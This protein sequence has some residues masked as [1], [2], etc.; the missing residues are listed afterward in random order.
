MS[1]PFVEM[2]YARVSSKAQSLAR[3]EQSIIEAVPDL[4]VQYFFKDKYTGKDF[5]NREQYQNMK[6]K[7]QELIEAN[8]STNIRV[9]VHELDR[10]GRDFQEIQKEIQWF[11]TMGVKLRF[12]DIP[13]EL[14]GDAT[15][16]TGQLLY[17]IIILLKS[18]WAEQEL[19]YKEKRVHEGI[20]RAHENG[21]IFGRKAIVVDEKLFKETAGKAVQ[22]N[23]SHV[24]AMKI[25]DMKPYLYWKHIHKY[26]PDYAGKHTTSK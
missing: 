17:R 13:E 6:L 23:I 15:G 8:S 4:K 19:M 22:H 24:D 20:A 21:V 10:L 9:T 12:L 18:Y 25:L 5:E 16:I 26:F 14:I 7:I 1:T 11:D 3:Q 2:A